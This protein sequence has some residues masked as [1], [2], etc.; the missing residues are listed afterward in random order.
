MTVRRIPFG[1]TLNFRDIGGYPV[2]GG[3]ATR[4]GAVYRSDS[5]HHLTADDLPAFDA[6]GV[7]A[8]YDL[9]RAGEIERFPGPREYV[10]LEVPGGDLGTA[11]FAELRTRQDGENWLAA[12]YAAMLGG[13]AAAFG[14]LFSRLARDGRLPAVVHCLGGKDRTGLAVA[15]LLTALG[16]ARDDVLDDYE[17]T[18][19]YQRPRLP[20]VVEAFAAQGM[21]RPAA[22]GVLGT[23][24]WAMARALAE[25]DESWGGIG[26]YLLGPCGMA[27][28]TLD[29]LRANLVG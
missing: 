2:R 1:G 22:E 7:K 11:A 24:R 17:L 23:P 13:A 25:L 4:W 12:D 26:A 18:S 8:I 20:E 16:A 21:A 5:L 19:E 9:R 14:E 29:A 28:G 6:L 27:P 10:H 3:G 15:L